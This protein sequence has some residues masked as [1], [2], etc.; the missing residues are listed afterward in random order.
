MILKMIIASQSAIPL[1]LPR[2]KI[3]HGGQ[4]RQKMDHGGQ[5][6][7]TVSPDVVG[8]DARIRYVDHSLGLAI[9]A[10]DIVLRRPAAINAGIA[11]VVGI[12]LHSWSLISEP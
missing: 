7:Q 12:A 8:Y 4:A 3:N 9:R 10:I 2:Q 1:H 5:A 11:C 6:R